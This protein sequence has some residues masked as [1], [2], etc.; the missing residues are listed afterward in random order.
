MGSENPPRTYPLLRRLLESSSRLTSRSGQSEPEPHPLLRPP[1]MTW[2]AN[3]TGVGSTHP[4]QVSGP[5]KF[6]MLRKLKSEANRFKTFLNWRTRN[7]TPHRLANAGFFYYNE[8]DKVQCVFCLGILGGWGPNDDPLR[9]HRHH[10]P[11]CP[12]VLG[13]AVGNIPTRELRGTLHDP[14]RATD[15]SEG[16]AG[17]TVIGI[18]GFQ[19]YV[20]IQKE[21]PTVYI[22]PIYQ[23]LE[24]EVELYISPKVEA[25]A[26][27][28]KRLETFSSWPRGLRQNGLT[29]AKAGF[30]YTGLGD[31]VRC[32]H[33]D[34]GLYGWMPN[35]CPWIEHAR[36]YPHCPHLNLIKGRKFAQDIERGNN[37]VGR[38]TSERSIMSPV[39]EASEANSARSEAIHGADIPDLEEGLSARPLMEDTSCRVCMT[40]KANVVI[41]PCAHLS[42]CGE[43]TTQMNGGCPI[44]RGPIKGFVRV[45]PY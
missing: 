2:A 7:P 1:P 12:F 35:D 19:S 28:E 29:M 42:T 22:N 31:N 8:E 36:W 20:C 33:C 13:V 14:G 21:T 3:E 27:L 9:E 26:P 16:R 17:N 25:L 4:P 37:P 18:L 43:C 40:R 38:Q 34:G 10:F 6:T 5:T 39:S 44:C 15:S 11:R 23:P 30:Y 24:L 41:L 32:Y 45:Y